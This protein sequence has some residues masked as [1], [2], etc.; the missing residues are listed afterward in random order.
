MERPDLESDRVSR[1]SSALSSR[2]SGRG[3]RRLSLSLISLVAV[4][5]A[6]GTTSQADASGAAHT[7]TKEELGLFQELKQK[8]LKGSSANSCVEA[9]RIIWRTSTDE[10]HRLRARALFERGCRLGN[11]PGCTL[12]GVDLDIASIDSVQHREKFDLRVAGWDQP[13]RA[14]SAEQRRPASKEPKK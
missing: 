5:A 9:G 2:L 11:R 13:I 7:I 3:I 6:A 4:L 1:P 8:C 14:P 12:K 10:E